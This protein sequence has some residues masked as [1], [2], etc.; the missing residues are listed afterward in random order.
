MKRFVTVTI[1]GLSPLAVAG[2]QPAPPSYADEAAVIEQTRLAVRFDADGTGRRELYMRVKALSE[3]GVQQLGQVVLGYNAASERLDI[4]FVRVRK[5]DG[6]VVTTP[7]DSV[8]DLSSP[9]QRVAPVYTDFREKH[10]TVQSFR[11]GDT[12]EVSVVTTIHTALAP[13]QFW[14]EYAFN[15]NDI[16]LDEQLDIDVPASK[17]VILKLKPGFEPDIKEENGR[18][19][20]H[21]ARSHTVRTQETDAQKEAK[22]KKAAREPERAPIRMTTFADWNEVGR[23]FASLEQTARRPT[24]EIEQKAR[25]LVAGRTTDLAKVE[26]LYDYVSKSFRYV[27]LSLGAGR[28][29]PRS[30]ADVL[31]DAYGDCKDKHTL[32]A[33]LMDAVGLKAAPALINSRIELDA[34]FPSPGQF[35]HVITRVVV[36]GES[37][38]LDA[39]P[40]VAPFRLLSAN[41]RRKQALVAAVS[42]STLEQTPPDPPVPALLATQVDGRIDEAGT[43][44]ASVAMTF[45]GDMELMVRTAFRM[46]PESQWKEIVNGML[47]ETGVKGT[48][49]ELKVSDPQATAAPFTVSF[50]VNAP[51]FA[52]WSGG[53]FDLPLPF[54][55]SDTSFPE[56]DVDES[57]PIDVGAQGQVS[58][59]LK[60]DVPPSV[61]VRA[62]VPVAVTRDYADYRATYAATAA[63]V[64]AERRLVVRDSQIPGTRNG[65]YV[66]F[67]RVV[68]GDARQ[69]LAVDASALAP[70]TAAVAPDV[71]AKELNQAGYQALQNRDYSRAVSL[72]RRVVE[73]EPKDRAAWN[74]LGRAH[75][76]LRQIDE[77]IAAYKKQIDVNPYDAYAYNNLGFAYAEQGKHAEAEAAY[78]KQLEVNPLDKYAHANL[79]YMLVTQR[80][81]EKAAPVLEQAAALTPDSAYLQVQLGKTYL[82]LRRAEDAT[83]AFARAV[84]ISPDPATWNNVAYQ[85]ALGGV[86][87]ARAQQYAES[88]VTATAAATRNLTL[89]HTD[90]RALGLVRSLASY[91]DTLGWVHFAKGDLAAAEKYVA[92][93]WQL[94]QH[95][96][97]GDH[98][99]Q[100]FEK[101]GRRDAAL[102]TYAQALA[103]SKP[104]PEV[105]EH[106]ER[107]AGS[108][109]RADA[110]LAEHRGDLSKARIIPLAHTGPAGKK[111]EFFV[112]FAAPA[113]EGV[114][115]IEGDEELRALI[116]VIQK[117]P[118]AGVFPDDTPAKLLR[119]GIAVC[120]GTRCSLTLLLP[121]DAKPAK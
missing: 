105:R 34:E 96:E 18:R 109:T 53:K 74:N 103:A 68:T 118:A 89:D 120:D 29:Q 87:L 49:S 1:V 59:T 90:D 50:A 100:I 69:R 41:L 113:V 26:A 47:Q 60:L 106:L 42:S 55:A 31:R 28:Y 17:R 97:V 75:M 85:L 78:R 102:R 80:H 82:N 51:L 94:A 37:V 116:P 104:P 117:L 84:E 56:P 79:G 64:S 93:S 19:R 63:T 16:V 92:A 22:R 81:Y 101:T 48:V 98:L 45:R 52:N 58:Y 15:E 9:V 121:D 8:Q 72:L 38:W 108:R 25:Q 95:A 39:T 88:A 70:T 24:P 62:P 110:L 65:D 33:S 6:T 83:K 43:L 5:A 73:L 10:V 99:A 35:D 13:G 12:L 76:G 46:V 21:W 71:Q 30:A 27:S 40:E 66:A 36:G 14:T 115:F 91:W 61:K 54:G 7:S 3:A 2:Q 107:A 20:Y 57:A 23:W 77:A 111:A 86:D 114:K 119:R 67:M 32:L 112:L 11:P 44:A 4:P